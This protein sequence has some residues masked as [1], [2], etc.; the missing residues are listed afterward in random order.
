MRAKRIAIALLQ[1]CVLLALVFGLY[2]LSI[3]DK[4]IP[5]AT[6]GDNDEDDVRY[7]PIVPVSIGLVTRTTLR[8]YIDAYGIIEPQPARPGIAAGGASVNSPAPSLVASVDVVEGQSVTAGQP[9]I[10]LDNRAFAASLAKAEQD[11]DSARRIASQFDDAAKSQ[12][13]PQAQVLRAHANRDAADAALA[14]AKAQQALLTLTSP[15]DGI[16]AMLRVRPGELTSLAIPAVEVV[17]PDRLVVAAHVPEW[18]LHALAIGQPVVLGTSSPATSQPS[19]QPG[20]D[21]TVT[22]IDP[23]IDP[24]TGLGQVDVALP[25][26]GRYRVGQFV[27]L[28]ITI[29]QHDDA[30]AVPAAS[31][32]RNTLGRQTVS[33]V[34]RDYHWAFRRPVQVG[35]RENG[36]VEVIGSDL[37]PGQFVVTTGAYALPDQSQIEVTP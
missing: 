24:Q 19:T 2:R 4:P 34:E 22:Y 37:K 11:A 18:Q 1:F 16:V 14:S 12:V 6:T 27:S 30:L 36:L 23:Q 33:V 25:P 29:D 13:V 26:N 31:V 9:V 32:V 20:I 15:I 3:P 10:H 35:I 17:N 7:N 5:T 28:R 21:A 8:E